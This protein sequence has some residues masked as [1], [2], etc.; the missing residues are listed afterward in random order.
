LALYDFYK[1]KKSGETDE[2]LLQLPKIFKK[3]INMVIGAGLREKRG[4]GILNLVVSSF[5]IGFL[6]SLLEAVCTGQ[7]YIPTIIYILKTTPMKLKAFTYLVLYNLMFI[8]PLIIIFILSLIGVSSNKFNL[9]LK[10]HI[11]AV[12]LA[13]VVLFFIL[14]LLILHYA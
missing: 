11:G 12:K 13:M 4:S 10:R 2:M 3:R 14:G 6:V 9:F 1:F 5:V 7:V 8:L